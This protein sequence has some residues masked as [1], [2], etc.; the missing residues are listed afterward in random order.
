MSVKILLVSST[1]SALFFKAFCDFLNDLLNSS[2]LLSISVALPL[3]KES[4][5]FIS[6][7]NFLTS[8][9]TTENPFP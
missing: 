2:V 5:F 9:A 4:R 6:P 1:L 7:D 8:S 3:T